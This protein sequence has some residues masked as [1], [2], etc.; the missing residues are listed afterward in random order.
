[1][2]VTMS[3]SMPV[4][5]LK[6]FC[7]HMPLSTTKVMLSM[8]SDVSATVVASTTFRTFG[9]VGSKHYASAPRATPTSCCSLRGSAE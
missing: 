1:M 7:L 6:E 4:R 9:G 3:E 8:V 2:G 5:G